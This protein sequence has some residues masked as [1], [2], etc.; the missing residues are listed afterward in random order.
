MECPAAAG[1]WRARSVASIPFQPTSVTAST[2]P[3]RLK[4]GDAALTKARITIVGFFRDADP[5]A[6]AARTLFGCI[7]AQR[8]IGHQYFKF[9]IKKTAPQRKR[10]P[11]SAA[12]IDAKSAF[13]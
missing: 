7:M 2:L 11:P 3:C 6:A 4:H 9:L 5:C 1:T 12:S 10:N 13:F 8:I